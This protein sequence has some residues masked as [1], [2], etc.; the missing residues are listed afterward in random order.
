MLLILIMGFLTLPWPAK[1][2]IQYFQVNG[3]INYQKLERRKEHSEILSFM[4]SGKQCKFDSHFTITKG[5]S[6]DV[7][8]VKCLPLLSTSK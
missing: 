3:I 5:N 8:T 6:E 4:I 1:F 2:H 7:P